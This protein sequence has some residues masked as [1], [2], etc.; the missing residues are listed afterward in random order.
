MYIPKYILAKDQDYNPEMEEVYDKLIERIR[1]LT[2]PQSIKYLDDIVKDPK[3]RFILSLGFG[4]PLADVDLRSRETFISCSELMPTQNEIDLDKSLQWILN[5]KQDLR[6]F[7]KN[8]VTVVSPIVSFKGTFVIDGHHR[9]SQAFICNPEVKIQAIDYSGKLSP[10]QMLKAVQATIGSNLGKIPVSTVD[11]KSLYA[12]SEEQL[13]VY[14]DKYLSK[15]AESQYIELVEKCNN[16][17]DVIMYL[18]DNAM[19]LKANNKPIMGAP[20]RNIMPQCDEDPSVFEDLDDGV[21][22]L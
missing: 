6:K 11:G 12:V 22:N 21:T 14:I 10:I 1:K 7:F 8:N 15:K 18:T 3:L 9:W 13:V 20:K 5:G 2:Y 4:G 17:D 19:Q 16:R